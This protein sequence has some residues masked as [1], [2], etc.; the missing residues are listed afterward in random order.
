MKMR[1][2]ANDENEDKEDEDESWTLVDAITGMGDRSWVVFDAC[3]DARIGA[4]ASPR[5]FRFRLRT[6]VVE[7]PPA[8]RSRDEDIDIEFEFE[9]VRARRRHRRDESSSSV[10]VETVRAIRASMKRRR[11]RTPSRTHTFIFII[12]TVHDT[13]SNAALRSFVT[14]RGTER[15]RRRVSL[16]VDPSRG[17]PAWRN[18]AN[19]PDTQSFTYIDHNNP[20]YTIR[21]HF[22]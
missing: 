7:T 11:D 1:T 2:F 9:F 14:T 20:N 8:R 22:M 10:R 16:P 13:A 17:A 12:R 15:L 5:A 21:T 3:D 18:Y 19:S 6:V 4:D